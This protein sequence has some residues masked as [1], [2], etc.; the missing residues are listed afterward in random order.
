MPGDL[1]EREGFG[2]FTWPFIRGALTLVGIRSRHF[3]VPVEGTKA[4]KNF[5][6]DLMVEAKE[7]GAMADGVAFFEDHQIYMAEASQIC[8]ARS[9]KG[10]MDKFKVVRSMRDSW[11]TQIQAIA[12]E[13][14][15]PAELTVFGSR[16]FKDE[17]LFFAMDFTGT[18][19]L[20]EV[21]RMFVP[22]RKSHFSRRMENCIRTCLKFALLLKEETTRRS[23]VETT[24]E[25][26][27]I[28]CDKIKQTR[29]TPIKEAKRRRSIKGV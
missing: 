12:Q 2:D 27:R 23:L 29:T 3:E 10:P 13:Y 16:S 24:H 17:T 22:L 14:K 7:S 1:N 18:Y 25:D 19:R 26:L 21:G 20:K 15:P 9:E 8:G 28:A 6:R 5:R 11:N 4:R